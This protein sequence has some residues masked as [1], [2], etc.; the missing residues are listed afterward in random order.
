M[1]PV[2]GS[3]QGIFEAVRAKPK[4][5]VFAEGEEEK[6]I[7]A[8]LEFRAAGYGLPILIGREERVRA[9][10]LLLAVPSITRVMRPGEPFRQ[11]PAATNAS[12]PSVAS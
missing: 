1:N 9:G 12:C 3:L 8:A 5:M 6:V 11:D 10:A 7:R 4:R 2:T